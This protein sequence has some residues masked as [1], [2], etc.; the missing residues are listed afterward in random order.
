MQITSI[1]VSPIE[2]PESSVKAVVSVLINGQLMLRSIRIIERESGLVVVNPSR[3]N[4]AGRYVAYFRG[5]TSESNKRLND[6]ILQVYEHAKGGK[7]TSI[8]ECPVEGEEKAL[9][10]TRVSVYPSERREDGTLAKINFE[11]D[12]EYCFSGAALR[13]QRNNEYRL[14]FPHRQLAERVQYLYHPIK[15]ELRNQL[16]AEAI[17]AYEAKC[18]SRKNAS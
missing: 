14:V 18:K 1:R 17:A 11:L 9:E 13:L 6:M 4:N 8:V 16:L 12:G 15:D 10:V 7:G 2:N 5:K 3:K